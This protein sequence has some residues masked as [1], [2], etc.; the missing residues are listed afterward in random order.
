M[1]KAHSN[2]SAIKDGH[3][4]EDFDFGLAEP[5]IERSKLEAAEELGC[6]AS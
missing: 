2:I 5:F 4:L 6:A 3:L 1:V